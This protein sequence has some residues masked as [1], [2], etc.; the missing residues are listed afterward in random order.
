MVAGQLT[1]DLNKTPIKMLQILEPLTLALLELLHR[2]LKSAFVWLDDPMV[3]RGAMNHT[4]TLEMLIN[5]AHVP[6]EQ[7]P[8]LAVQ[9]SQGPSASE[10]ESA[11]SA[12]RAVEAFENAG[13]PTGDLLPESLFGPPLLTSEPGVGTLDFLNDLSTTNLMPSDWFA[14]FET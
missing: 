7:Q 9:L 10:M 8:Q 14:Y 12:A 6:H 11:T 3:K 2:R 5:S 4:N 13:L 1:S